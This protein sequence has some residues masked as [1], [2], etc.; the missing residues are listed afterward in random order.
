MKSMESIGP[1]PAQVASHVYRL[2]TENDRVR[3]FDVRFKPGDKA[4]MHGHP[5]HVLYVFSDGQNKLT[6]PNGES[7]V[8]DLKAGAALWIDAG[9]HATENVGRTDVHLLVIELKK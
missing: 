2:I 5:G 6:F 9:Q 3:I 7:K 1:D 8:F 4:V